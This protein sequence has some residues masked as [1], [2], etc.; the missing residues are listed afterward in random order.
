MLSQCVNAYLFALCA[1]YA[2][3]NINTRS[4]FAHY[5]SIFI[6]KIWYQVL[7]I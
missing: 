6:K 3:T 2:E 1:E 7:V 4:V 5:G